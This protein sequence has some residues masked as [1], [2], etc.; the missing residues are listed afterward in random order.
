MR[1]LLLALMLIATATP[2]G[3]EKLAS[4]VSSAT[5]QIT[6]S[7][8]GAVLSLF[9]TIESDVHGLAAPGPYNVI[10]IVTGPLQ[11]RVPRLK[12]NNWGI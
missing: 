6:S 3:A 5:I 4:T 8:D 12:T 7:F 9:G 2:V 11:H 10:V 1:R